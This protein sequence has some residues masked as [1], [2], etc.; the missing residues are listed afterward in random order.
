MLTLLSKLEPKDMPG[1]I[2][3]SSSILP[4]VAKPE[5]LTSKAK[6]YIQHTTSF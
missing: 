4:L 6:V 5:Q 1:T 2:Q 3:L